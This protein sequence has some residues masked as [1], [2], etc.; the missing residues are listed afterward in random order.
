MQATQAKVDRQHTSQRLSCWHSGCQ[1]TVPK[2]LAAGKRERLGDGRRS[3]NFYLAFVSTFR[4]RAAWLT[5]L[6]AA[7]LHG[8]VNGERCART[9]LYTPLFCTGRRNE[10]S[11]RE[12][13]ALFLHCGEHGALNA[14]HTIG[15]GRSAYLQTQ[16]FEPACYYRLP[17]RLFR[18][19]R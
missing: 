4:H 19:S 15:Y 18:S 14:P 8:T 12:L 13:P 10:P 6:V 7:F 16:H 5:Y 9:R 11:W 1:R 2:L 17:F 3:L